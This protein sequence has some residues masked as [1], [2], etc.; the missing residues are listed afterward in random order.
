M[1]GEPIWPG[2]SDLDQLCMIKSSLGQLTSSQMHTLLTQSIYDQVSQ[3][4]K[5]RDDY[6]GN[7]GQGYNDC[8][9]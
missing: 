2:K 3:L 6:T 4:L 7:H 8:S 1:R 9:M 5:G